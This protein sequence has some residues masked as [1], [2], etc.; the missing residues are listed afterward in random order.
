M[1][2]VITTMSI[3]AKN[4]TANRRPNFGLASGSDAACCASTDA[5]T[6]A[7]DGTEVLLSFDPDV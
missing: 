5:R 7:D 2:K 4:K 3:T 6:E 1:A